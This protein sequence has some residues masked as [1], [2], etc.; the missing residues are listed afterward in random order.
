MIASPATPHRVWTRDRHVGALWPALTFGV[1]WTTSALVLVVSGFGFPVLEVAIGSVYLALAMITIRITED[2]PFERQT[3]GRRQ[4]WAQVGVVGAFIVLTGWNGLVFHQVRGAGPIPAWTTLTD[5]LAKIGGRL[6]G[7]DNYV[8]NPVLYAALPLVLLLVLGARPRDLGFGP[9][10]RVLRVIALWAAIPVGFL[11]VAA[12]T[13][14][15][16]VDRIGRR[17]VSN[18]MQNG[19]WEEFLLR[20]ALQSRLR[21]LLTPEWAIVV[22][23][24]VFGAWHL[25]LGYTNTEGAGLLPALAI[26]IVHQATIGLAFG[27]VFE[28]TRNLLAPSV[29]HVLANTMG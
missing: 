27:I 26:G 24:L 22:Q 18:I 4:L 7:N 12:L 9:G 25:G 3:I 11:I 17:L 29:A 10:H 2:A 19:F 5:A 13:G 6:F 16:A 20:G 15:L 23:A 8:A 28:R 14:Q 21:A 1:A